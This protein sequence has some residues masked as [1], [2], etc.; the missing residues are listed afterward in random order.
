[1]AAR[2]LRKSLFGVGIVHESAEE[3][4][5]PKTGTGRQNMILNF[6]VINLPRSMAGHI[7]TV[8]HSLHRHKVV[9]DFDDLSL[10]RSHI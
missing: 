1:M 4:P 8:Y 10:Q 3:T 6:Y 5:Q 9:F 2:T 7:L